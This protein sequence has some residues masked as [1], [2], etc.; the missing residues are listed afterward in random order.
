LGLTLPFVA[1]SFGY[2]IFGNLDMQRLLLLAFG[3]AAAGLYFP[4]YWISK[5]VAVRQTNIGYGFPDALDMLLVCV[6]AGASFAAALQRVSQD[7]GRSH[8][9]LGEE[10]G[11]I[12]AGLN[13]GQ[14]REDALR[15]FAERAGTEDVS[16]FVTIMVQSEAFGTSV[17]DSLRVQAA[18]MR[19]KRLLRAEEMAN[20]LPVK[21]TFPMSAM[22]FPTLLI[23][24][25]MPVLM[26]IYDA[27][28]RAKS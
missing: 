15:Q 18:E 17:A 28:D 25:L 6:E 7:V 20:K 26:R 2:L 4:N 22:I 5:R 27:F 1:T 24:I 16:S 21:L 3:S 14:S 8:P 9:V 19:A 10:L 13:A 12:S 11:L 23:I